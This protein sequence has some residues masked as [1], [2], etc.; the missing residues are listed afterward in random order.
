MSEQISTVPHVDPGLAIG[1]DFG[2]KA[3]LNYAT[4]RDLIEHYSAEF[5]IVFQ[6]SS[7]AISKRWII[8]C[9]LKVGECTRLTSE[10][11]P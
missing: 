8:P 11:L 10:R 3:L 1:D 7:K 4:W 2:R 6:A 5:E 9:F